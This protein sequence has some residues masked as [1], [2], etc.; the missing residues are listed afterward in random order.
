MYASVCSFCAFVGVLVRTG[1]QGISYFL[2]LFSHKYQTAS[3]IY[4]HIC[5]YDLHKMHRKL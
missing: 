2:N 5:A 3:Y 4:P 1:V